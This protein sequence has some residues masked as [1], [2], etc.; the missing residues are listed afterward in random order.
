MPSPR[1]RALRS[2]RGDVAVGTCVSSHAPRPDPYV[3]L[4]RIRLV[5][6][7]RCQGHITPS[8]L[9]ACCFIL[10]FDPRREHSSVPTAYCHRR[11]A[12]Q[13]SR[14]ALFSAAEGLSLTIASTAAGYR[15]QDGLA[16]AIRGEP[17]TG[18]GDRRANHACI[19][20]DPYRVP[21]MKQSYASAGKAPKRRVHSPIGIAAIAVCGLPPPRIIIGYPV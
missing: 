2:F 17:A 9:R 12:Q 15:G 16:L 19:R 21:T 18:R 20:L 11:R 1:C 14:T 7:F 8:L 13:W 3:R 6:G 4:S 10:L 5:W